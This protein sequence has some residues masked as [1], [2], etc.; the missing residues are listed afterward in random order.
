MQV[1]ITTEARLAAGK[2]EEADSTLTSKRSA[3]RKAKQQDSLVF[4]SIG[5]SQEESPED[6]QRAGALL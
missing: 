1:G 6:A 5:T 3:P 2:S 4:H